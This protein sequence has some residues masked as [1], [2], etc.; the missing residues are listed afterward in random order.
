MRLKPLYD[1]IS[2]SIYFHIL[3]QMRE[4]YNILG[5]ASDEDSARR[6]LTRQVMSFKNVLFDFLLCQLHS[7]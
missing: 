2:L 7:K 4:V 6:R 1:P 3:D 5:E